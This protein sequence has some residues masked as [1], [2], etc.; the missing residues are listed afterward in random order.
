MITG[1]VPRGNVM[2]IVEVMAVFLS[3]YRYAHGDGAMIKFPGTEQGWN[4]KAINCDSTLLARFNIWLS[5]VKARQANGEAWNLGDG[6]VTSWKEVFPQIAAW[7]GLE[8][9]APSAGE[10]GGAEAYA[11]WKEKGSEAYKKMVEEKG[12][13]GLEMGEWQWGFLRACTS[14]FVRDRYLD[15]RKGRAL[16]WHETQEPTKGFLN[17]FDR[18]ASFHAIP[19]W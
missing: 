1:F 8:A 19:K 7:F 5:T 18:Y 9:V 10:D 2:N 11:W 15:L 4:T 3:T 17:A 12:L 16:G 13:K 6:D 14:V